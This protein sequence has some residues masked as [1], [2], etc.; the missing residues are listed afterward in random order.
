MDIRHWAMDGSH[1]NT[2][3]QY[4]SFVKLIQL[5]KQKNYQLECLHF[6]GLNMGRVLAVRN[7][8]ISGY[9]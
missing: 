7:R 6:T 8:T 2:P 1:K 4:L 3:W 5:L 9:K